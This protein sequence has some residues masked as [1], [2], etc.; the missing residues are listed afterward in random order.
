MPVFNAAKREIDIK[1]V[2]YGPALCGKTT[3]VHSIHK[4]LPPTQRGEIMALATKDDR[5]LFFDF[6]SIELGNVKGFKTRFHVYTVPGQVYYALTR[7]AVLT[8]VDGVIFVADSQQDKMQENVESLKDLEEN[9]GYYKKELNTIPFV[10]QYNK[11]DLENILPV[12]QM[13]PVLNQRGVPFFGASAKSG[14][15]VMETLTACCKLVLKKLNKPQRTRPEVQQTQPEA[16]VTQQS[17]QSDGAAAQAGVSVIDDSDMKKTPV[18]QQP[19]PDLMEHIQ[20]QGVSVVSDNDVADDIGV[21]TKINILPEHEG[22]SIIEDDAGNK[23]RQYEMRVSAPETPGVASVDVPSGPEGV[24][25]EEGKADQDQGL[26]TPDFKIVAC[27]VPQKVSD[28]SVKIPL[29]CALEGAGRAFE[30]NLSLTV[31]I[32]AIRQKG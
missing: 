11:R 23:D 22:V 7:R 10:M 27:G 9:L 2:Y 25:A 5:T 15:G 1:I 21:E 16:A 14:E 30:V 32:D 13:D 20:I 26:Q 28:V 19:E 17:A 31:D 4:N 6:L 24:P 12:E 8:G 18:E 3:N 29:I